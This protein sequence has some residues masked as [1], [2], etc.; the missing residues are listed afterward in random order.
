[1][2]IL[3][4]VDCYVPSAKSGAKQMRD[5]AVEFHRQGHDVIVLTSSHEITGDAQIAHEKGVRIVR[6]RTG[7]IKGAGKI[8]RAVEEIRLSGAVWRRAG[9]FLLENP[10]DLIVF[11][12]PTIFWGALVRRLKK[13]WGCPAYLILRDIFPQWAVDAGL[14]RRGPVWRFFRKKEIEQYDVA[15]KIGIQSPANAEYFAKEFPLRKYPLD[16][17]YNWMALQEPE[18]P[19]TDYRRKLGLQDKVVFVYG[20][21]LGVAQDMDNIV[22]LAARL[23]RHT[24][25]HFLLVGEGSEVPRL[26]RLVAAKAL[27]NVQILP[28]VGQHEYLA[29]LSEW[30]AGLI[31]LDRRLS[32]HNLPGKMLG[33][34]Y[35][36][37]PILA[38]INP[39]NDL[40]DLIEKNDAGFCL[41]N[42]EDESLAA[43][44]L[45]LSND[46]E[47]RAKMGV[48]ARRL[49]E[50]QFS[51]GAAVHQI[52]SFAAQRR[53]K[54][55][56]NLVLQAANHVA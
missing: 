20:G 16:V 1:M 54:A 33:Y 17:L 22:R 37:M 6:V 27:S 26:K 15:D 2:R 55:E 7:K 38:S 25:I 9:R 21:N 46:P 42:G 41:Q 43:A 19:A 52:I 48:N 14:L 12:S 23:A 47:L 29:M 40:F 4:L 53:A 28:A 32:T 8:W 49:L 51:V 45:I 39:G 5:L 44:A 35:W 56:E 18:L 3:I 10:A 11:Y 36:G 31:S 24:H 13:L 30:D 34:M 50:R